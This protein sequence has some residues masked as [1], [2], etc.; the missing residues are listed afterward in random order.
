[1]SLSSDDWHFLTNI[2]TCYEQYCVQKFIESHETI[3]LIPPK[4]PYRSRI[5]L[6]RL[7]D[8]IGVSD[9]DES[10]MTTIVSRIESAARDGNIHIANIQPQKSVVQKQ[11]KFLGVELEIDGQWLDIVH[12]LY[13]LQQEPNFYFINELNL[14]KYS[15]MTNSLRGRIVISRMCLVNP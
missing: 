6:Q 14:E 13:I 4:Q 15:D 12:F 5:K 7:I 8:L 1:M 3:P 2:R 10:Q 9:S 11:V